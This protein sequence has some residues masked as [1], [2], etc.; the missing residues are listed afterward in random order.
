VKQQSKRPII[1]ALIKYGFENF[2]FEIIE[3][4]DFLTNEQIL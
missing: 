4:C 3:N 2:K 1:Q